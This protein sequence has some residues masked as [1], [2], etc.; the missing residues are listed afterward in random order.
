[1]FFSMNLAQI[2]SF[3]T[4]V[5]AGSFSKAAKVMHLTQPALSLQ[6]RD[7][8]DALHV[9]LLERTHRGVK[10][11]KA[12]EIVFSYGERMLSM[13]KNMLRELELQ[14]ANNTEQLRI[15]ASTT[16]GSYAVPCSIYIFK[17][18]YPN[19]K[20]NLTVSNSA[21]I[22]KGI[23]DGN[24]DVALL[25]GPLDT[26]HNMNK[27]LVVRGI[28]T[29]ELILIVPPT[30]EW[31]ERKAITLEELK[32]LPLIV[33]EEGSG[34]RKA[35]ESA[36]A[37][38]GLGLADMNIVMELNNL[39]AIKASVEA[40]R[41]VALISRIAIRK[42]LRHL[43]LHAVRVTGISFVYQFTIVHLKMQG[44]DPLLQAFIAF[45]RSPKE[46]HFC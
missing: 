36:L 43:S 29:D 3:I 9:Q 27:D 35:I 2:E 15:G 28:G 39:D 40:G 38:H 14:R 1:M 41:G 24:L 16:L 11:T 10:L 25:E 6:V 5:R 4:V 13:Q 31:A 37:Q 34:M 44:L 12:G 30:G 19:A 8:E 22:L 18:R 17:E 32:E 33:R 20:I 21:Q 42:E 26:K 46:R 7:L 23:L 45:I